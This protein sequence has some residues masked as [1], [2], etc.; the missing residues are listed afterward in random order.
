[1]K[2]ISR[3][4]KW[5]AVL[6]GSGVVSILF[7]Y[8]GS[9][10]L[11]PLWQENKDY[12]S[13][14]ENL[15]S[16]N[17]QLRQDIE[18]LKSRYLHLRKRLDMYAPQDVRYSELDGPKTGIDL[19]PSPNIPAGLSGE[20]LGVL[21][22]YHR[23]VLERRLWD[24]M[25]QEQYKSILEAAVEPVLIKHPPLNNE[26][27]LEYFDE[28]AASLELHKKLIRDVRIFHSE[29]QFQNKHT[30]G[31]TPYQAYDYKLKLDPFARESSIADAMQQA[32]SALSTGVYYQE[33]VEVLD[34]LGDEFTK[35]VRE[36]YERL[37]SS[38]GALDASSY[39]YNIFLTFAKKIMDYIDTLAGQTS[40]PLAPKAL[41]ELDYLHRRLSQSFHDLYEIGQQETIDAALLDME[42]LER[43]IQ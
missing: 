11:Y 24:R 25:L 35:P 41:G 3:I 10:Y 38:D 15:Y 27:N 12:A 26:A 29:I 40:V 16:E 37:L 8:L 6:S 7:L 31:H 5:L 14:F 17:E 18:L 28:L 21:N 42:E 34:R 1:M 9:L 19:L 39:N 30:Q 33:A 2:P 36:E 4:Y 22:A 23:L 20:G 43:A 13:E 32:L